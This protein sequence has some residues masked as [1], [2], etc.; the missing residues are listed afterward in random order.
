MRR[1]LE[2]Q[3]ASKLVSP[4]DQ[5]L[6]GHSGSHPMRIRLDHHRH[7]DQA[8]RLAIPTTE[9]FLKCGKRFIKRQGMLRIGRS[10]AAQF[11]CEYLA[12]AK[13]GLRL[14]RGAYEFR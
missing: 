11:F 10:A 1:Y 2:P 9:F 7:A 4:A 14:D 13:F 12:D 3:L 8:F 6:G 5:L